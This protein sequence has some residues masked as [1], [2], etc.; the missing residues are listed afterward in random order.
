MDEWDKVMELLG[1]RGC[2]FDIA[3][4]L[5][6]MRKS[7]SAKELYRQNEDYFVFGTDSPWADQ[8]RYVHLIETSQTLSDEQREKMF[9]KNIL[10]L[11]R[12]N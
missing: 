9:Y 7:E 3:F 6:M 4:V 12:I 10:K 5:D 2:Y 8:K 1:G 11:I